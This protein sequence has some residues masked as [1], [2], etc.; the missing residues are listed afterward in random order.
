M[1]ALKFHGYINTSNVAHAMN[2]FIVCL[3]LWGWTDLFGIHALQS[4]YIYATWSDYS[5]NT[6]KKLKMHPGGL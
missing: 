3:A 2:N 6:G 5:E 4:A 1:K